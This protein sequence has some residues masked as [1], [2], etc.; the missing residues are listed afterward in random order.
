MHTYSMFPSPYVFHYRTFAIMHSPTHTKRKKCLAVW[1]R[2]DRCGREEL[3]GTTF[4]ER[5]LR[6]VQPFS[7][8]TTCTY[9]GRV[10]TCWSASTR[11]S[12]A[13]SRVLSASS[14]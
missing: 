7:S 9:L 1:S 13:R 12:K 6:A 11:P 14:V 3:A 5:N 10:P 2:Y 4:H 8:I